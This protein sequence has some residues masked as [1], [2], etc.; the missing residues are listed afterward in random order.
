ML[1]SNKISFL[2]STIFRINCSFRVFNNQKCTIL[3][4]HLNT[5]F[6][7]LLLFRFRRR[8]TTGA[9]NILW[10]IWMFTSLSLFACNFLRSFSFYFLFIFYA[11]LCNINL[12]LKWLLLALRRSR[13]RLLFSLWIHILGLL[14]VNFKIL[15]FDKTI[16]NAGSLLL[17]SN[18]LNFT[19]LIVLIKWKCNLFNLI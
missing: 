14:F 16:G 15:L 1:F 3:L 8:M 7:T 4:L 13:H 12:I 9:I 6:S 19:T 17:A 2:V 18:H 5:T 10:W 11:T